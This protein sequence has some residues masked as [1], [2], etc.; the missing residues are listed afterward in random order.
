MAKVAAAKTGKVSEPKKKKL[1]TSSAAPTKRPTKQLASS[2]DEEPAPAADYAN[3]SDSSDYVDYVF[4]VDTFD[5]MESKSDDNKYY[6]QGHTH[7]QC[8]YTQY[9]HMYDPS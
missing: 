5:R 1:R 8:T 4:N 2:G 3:L 9:K 6:N 7:I